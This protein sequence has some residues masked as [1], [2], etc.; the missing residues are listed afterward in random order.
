MSKQEKEEELRKI[1][2][3]K[4]KLKNQIYFPSS[5]ITCN[6]G[7]LV[8]DV[9]IIGNEFMITYPGHYIDVFVLYNLLFPKL[10][11]LENISIYYEIETS[12]PHTHVIISLYEPY[13]I[14]D[15]NI[16]DLTM[17]VNDKSEVI[18]SFIY[19]QSHSQ[20]KR[21]ATVLNKT[22]LQT[23]FYIQNERLRL[24]PLRSPPLT[25]QL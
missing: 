22:I 6:C 23:I 2:L 11:K 8:D 17:Q 10:S 3:L 19:N 5:L 21:M 7:S 16:F 20:K 15:L 1:E 13:T 12:C 25:K 9:C 14:T 4:H 24:G 18:K